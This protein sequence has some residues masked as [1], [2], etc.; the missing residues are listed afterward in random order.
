MEWK[1]FCILKKKFKFSWNLCGNWGSAERQM[2]AV[3]RQMELDLLLVFVMLNQKM[4][5]VEKHRSLNRLIQNDADV[6][7]Q[8]NGTLRYVRA[9][10]VVV[11]YCL[12]VGVPPDQSV[13]ESW[14]AKTNPLISNFNVNTSKLVT[15]VYLVLRDSDWCIEYGP[16]DDL[17]TSWRRLIKCKWLNWYFWIELE[18]C[19]FTNEP[20]YR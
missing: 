19:V 8:S 20:L 4:G 17:L 12:R 5:S 1:L 7:R 10:N 15:F 3:G 14:I 13:G 2:Q 16:D 11:D 9:W 6:C 18:S